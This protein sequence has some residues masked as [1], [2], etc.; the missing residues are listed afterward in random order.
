[1]SDRSKW[2]SSKIFECLLNRDIL[3]SID[4]APSARFQVELIYSAME[5]NW[6][7]CLREWN[8]LKSPTFFTKWMKS[9][10]ELMH[11]TFLETF[12][13]YFLQRFRLARERDPLLPCGLV[14]EFLPVLVISVKNLLQFLQLCH[15]D[16]RIQFWLRK[17]WSEIWVDFGGNPG[18]IAPIS[19]VS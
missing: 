18:L 17:W 6:K 3:P 12:Q 11:V 5:Q 19:I 8:T 4:F 1:M 2:H 14:S 10:L 7:F 9:M 15:V 16:Q 13:F